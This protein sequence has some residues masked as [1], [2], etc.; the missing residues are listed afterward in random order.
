MLLALLF[1]AVGAAACAQTTETSVYDPL[2]GALT[3]L[4]YDYDGDGR[5]DVRTFIRQGRPVRLEGDADGDGKV[6]RW[7]YYRADGTLDHA[8]G[9]TRHDGVEDTWVYRVAGE[10]RM[11]VSTQ[12]DG[13]VDR[14]EFYRGDEVVRTES[15]SNG[16]GLMD[17][18]EEYDRG[19]LALVSIDDN[20]RSGR[21]TRR[22]VYEAGGATRMEVDV[23][24]DGRFEPAG[25]PVGGA[26]AAR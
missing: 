12:R 7:E 8:G 20:Q 2:T 3:R 6:D 5:I 15:D 14:R 1:V 19:R 21:P 24:G 22:L 17:H 9:S 18:W 25:S 10:T 23:D 16:D 13:R 4:D 11:D 26:S